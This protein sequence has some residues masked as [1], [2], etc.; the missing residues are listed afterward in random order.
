MVAYLESLSFVNI[1]N[2]TRSAASLMFGADEGDKDGGLLAKIN[3]FTLLY[4]YAMNTANWS[5]LFVVANSP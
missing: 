2:M 1:S 4:S 5:E 3:L